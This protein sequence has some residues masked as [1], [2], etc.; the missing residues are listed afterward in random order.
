MPAA[1]GLA[2]GDLRNPTSSSCGFSRLGCGL[3]GINQAFEGCGSWLR[4]SRRSEIP[5]QG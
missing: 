5:G 2:A 4:P 3:P 1:F